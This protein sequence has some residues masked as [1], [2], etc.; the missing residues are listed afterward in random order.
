VFPAQAQKTPFLHYRFILLSNQAICQAPF[1]DFWN[2]LLA[3]HKI[4]P[5]LMIFQLKTAHI[6]RYF[7]KITHVG[8]NDSKKL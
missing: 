5:N 6:V 3:M 2:I 8:R 7:D 4:L 1:Q